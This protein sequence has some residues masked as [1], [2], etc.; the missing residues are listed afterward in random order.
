MKQL[1]KIAMLAAAAALVSQA[2]DAAF[3]TNDLYLGFNNSSAQGDY[4]ID[5]G[6]AISAVGVGGSSVKDLSSL[7]SST[8]FSNVFSATGANGVNVAVVG[9]NYNYGGYDVYATAVRAG[10]AGTPAVAG[11]NLGAKS[12]SSGTLSAAAGTLTGNPWPVSGASAV[13]STFSY[14]K[15]VGPDPSADFYAASGVDPFATFG[16]PAIVYLDLWYATV[17]NGYAYQGYFK[18]DLSGA[19]PSLTFTPAAAVVY[20]PPPQPRLSITRAGG[21]SSISFLSSSNATYTLFY[22]NAAGLPAPVANWPSLPGTITG[23]GL[24]NTF[25]D[26]TTDPIRLYKVKAQ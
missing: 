4:I 17:P 19:T 7:F 11:S 9:G 25:Q 26:T 20:T 18:V 2:A 21:V 5:I 15:A 1:T 3:T 10:G 14:T 22:T 8:T 16:S 6:N 23:N 24:T 13:D 12:H